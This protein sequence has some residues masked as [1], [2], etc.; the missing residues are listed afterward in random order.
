MPVPQRP[1]GVVFPVP[2]A[3]LAA[4]D[5]S[6]T[7]RRSVAGW[8]LYDFA[9]VIFAT[10]ILSI[11]FPIW[12]VDK[13]GASDGL[14]GLVNGASMALVFALA[15]LLGVALD[16]I[17]RRV[18]LLVISTLVACAS[19][20]AIGT[21]GVATALVLFF[22]GNAVFQLGVIVYD[23]LLPTVSTV[24]RRGRLS[25]LGIAAGFAGSVVGVLLGVVVLAIDGDGEPLVFRLTALLFLVA[26]VP[27]FLW[28]RE[29]SHP[30]AKASWRADVR[31]L[32]LEVRATRAFL[33]GQPRLQRFLLGRLAY[34]DAANT[35]VAFLGIY[36]TKELGFGDL[37][38]QLLFLS[39]I[40]IG[41]LGAIAA[42]RMTDRIGPFATLR[43]SLL[44]WLAVF[45]LAA[46]VPLL[47][48]PT[49]LFW[50]IAPLAGIALG[51]TPT[52]D[53]PAL[54]AIAPPAQFGR[55]MG[56]FAMVGRFSSVTG[57]LVWAAIVAGLGWGR[58]V[59]VSTLAVA[60]LFAWWWLGPL[61][62]SR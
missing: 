21:G 6:P 59:A 55:A 13:A 49:A 22:A 14:Y 33:R 52:S 23:S 25:G 34:T 24:E 12:V 54:I 35:M 53:R 47:R 46:G 36:A 29:P 31:A 50:G 27:C 9:N 18:P 61:T 45:T 3:G 51:A 62:E 1:P 28:V 17:P 38:V 39:G 15:P 26:A 10:N 5:A 56:L 44:V 37:A 40:L 43:R 2:L 8:I 58:P 7:G 30:A 57:P 42:G 19:I 48:L 11:T 20:A 41:P 16:R 60:M 4:R 32:W